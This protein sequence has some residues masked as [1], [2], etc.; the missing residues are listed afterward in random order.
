M[1]PYLIVFGMG[2]PWPRVI[3]PIVLSP[4]SGLREERGHGAMLICPHRQSSIEARRHT[5]LL[6]STPCHAVFGV[7][8]GNHKYMCMV[9]GKHFDF[10][11]QQAGLCRIHDVSLFGKLYMFDQLLL[12]L[13]N[14]H[15]H[16]LH[17]LRLHA[18]CIIRI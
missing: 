10:M 16:R 1:K 4:L 12:D 8:S 5:S 7:Y 14:N 15:T 13:S 3:G 11:T 6:R 2:V 17:E 18:M 9:I